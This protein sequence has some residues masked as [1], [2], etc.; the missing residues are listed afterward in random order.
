ME[1]LLGI[2]AECFIYD[3]EVMSMA[4]MY[5]PLGI[6]AMLYLLFMFF[7]WAVLTCPLWIPLSIAF[8]SISK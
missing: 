8:S 7:K 3:I 1:R 2:L 4:W 6:P 5:I